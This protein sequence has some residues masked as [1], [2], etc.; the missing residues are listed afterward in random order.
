MTA[1]P[2]PEPA[3]SAFAAQADACHD[4]GSPLVATICALVA[5]RGLPDSTTR[6]RIATWPGAIGAREAAVPLR[7]A[8]ALHRLVLDGADDGLVAA[9]PPAD[10]DRDALWHALRAAVS[11]HDGFI[12]ACLDS[13]PQTNEVARAALLL[14]ALL[15]LQAAHGLPIRLLELGASAGLNQNLDRF[16]YD[17]GAWQWGDPGSPVLVACQWRGT[18]RP[19]EGRDLEIADRG[20]CDL[21]PVPVGTDDER[22]RLLSYA[23]ADQRQ[24]LAR[25]SAAMDLARAHP[26]QVELAGAADWLEDRLAPL[27]E[28][29]LTVVLHTIMW[30]YL[31][32]AERA[33][34]ETAIRRAGRD[35]KPDRPLAWLRF[36]ADG[37]SPGGGV[38][39]TAWS[40]V[41][42][43]GITGRVA[44]GDYHGRWL[45]MG[46]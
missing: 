43:D 13:P 23:W 45:E 31:P 41:A 3:A 14:P 27:P 2:L 4:L 15:E 35:A 18:A 16:A 28:G 6:R 33:R 22:K 19:P 20:A 12:A 7:L 10:L 30:Q 34:A 44:R 9:F 46:S 24:R 36:E 21:A 11:A 25:L 32:D 42:D 8:A 39:L 38:Y 26:P 1:H 5:E 17:Y 40:D 37:G 29:R